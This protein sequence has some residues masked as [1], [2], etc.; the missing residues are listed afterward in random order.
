MRTSSL[1]LSPTSG[2]HCELPQADTAPGLA[3][4]VPSD[5]QNK[6]N[7]GTHKTWHGERASCTGSERPCGASTGKCAVQ[8]KRGKIFSSCRCSAAHGATE[9]AEN[10]KGGPRTG[11]T[12]PTDLHRTDGVQSPSIARTR[13]K[14]KKK[15]KEIDARHA[16]GGGAKKGGGIYRGGG[17][18][19]ARRMGFEKEGERGEIRQRR[20][21]RGIFRRRKGTHSVSD[22]SARVSFKKDAGKWGHSRSRCAAPIK[23]TSTQYPF[24]PVDPT[25]TPCPSASHH[26]SIAAGHYARVENILRGNRNQMDARGECARRP[27]PIRF[28]PAHSP[29]CLLAVRGGTHSFIPPNR[30]PSVQTMVARGISAVDHCPNRKAKG[31]YGTAYN[32]FNTSGLLIG[33]RARQI[34]MYSM[35][36]TFCA[37]NIVHINGWN[38]I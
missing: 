38:I 26:K 32:T 14:K 34:S 7:R 11:S 10:A 13:K 4:S 37:S 1:P 36:H 25:K 19:S 35:V 8:N 2:L 28:V 23:T 3:S 27:M 20:W 22:A 16:G 5:K 9:A 18:K 6:E 12:G 17:I 24:P 21:R 29:E 30:S 33:F 31:S 15:K